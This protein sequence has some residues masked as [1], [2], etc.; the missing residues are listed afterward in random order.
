MLNL[1]YNNF[2]EKHIQHKN[3]LMQRDTI[4]QKNLDDFKLDNEM[5]KAVEWEL[6]NKPKVSGH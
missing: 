3:E 1:L 2:L 5:I 4:A 6:T